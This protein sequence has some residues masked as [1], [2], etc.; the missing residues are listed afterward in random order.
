M[1]I[2]GIYAKIHRTECSSF[3]RRSLRSSN[4]SKR[5]SSKRYTGLST[6]ALQRRSQYHVRAWPFGLERFTAALQPLGVCANGDRWLL[7]HDPSTG[8]VFVRHEPNLPSGGQVA[9]IEAECPLELSAF[10]MI[11]EVKVVGTG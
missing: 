9:D 2:A 10:E 3:P 5:R 8:R 11:L 4:N 7:A 1:E 6:W